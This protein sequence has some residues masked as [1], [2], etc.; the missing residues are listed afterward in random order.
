MSLA[1]LE[2]Q[3]LSLR[4]EFRAWLVKDDHY[5]EED[6]EDLL[7]KP[8]KAEDH[9]FQWADN[10]ESALEHFLWCEAEFAT[11]KVYGSS[12]TEIRTVTQADVEDHSSILIYNYETKRVLADYDF[13]KWWHTAPESIE[14][15]LKNLIKQLTE[16][17][18]QSSG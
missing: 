10:M 13:G 4:D 18:P 15:D 7:D 11:I 8:W 12:P 6:L 16:S 5:D 3:A 2:T 17:K 1:W 9:P 14:E